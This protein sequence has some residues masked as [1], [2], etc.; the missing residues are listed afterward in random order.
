MNELLPLVAIAAV[1]FGVALSI[2]KGYGNR[3]SGENFN[4]GRL[5]SSLI[6]GVMGTMSISMITLSFVTEQINEIGIIAFAV[7]FVIQGFGT[8]AGLSKLDK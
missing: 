7:G 6:I 4:F 1:I 5:A 3:P 2:A 8:D